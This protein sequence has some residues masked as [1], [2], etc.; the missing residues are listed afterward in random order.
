MILHV[1]LSDEVADDLERAAA[2]AGVSPATWAASV[3]RHQGRRVAAGLPVDVTGDVPLA[4]VDPEPLTQR[5]CLALAAV[6]PRPVSGRALA[7]I[8]GAPR[9]HVLGALHDLH[10]GAVVDRVGYR[11]RYAAWRVT[12][13]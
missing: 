11:G 3:L 1:R 13:R 12:A 2:A 6:S 4:P 9:E 8:L 7:V 5:V 10:A